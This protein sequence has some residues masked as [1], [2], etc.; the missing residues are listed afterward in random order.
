[1]VGIDSA[2]HTAIN[3]KRNLIRNGDTMYIYIL[4]NTIN[5]K[6]YIG[7]SIKDPRITNGRIHHHFSLRNP[8]CRLIHRAIKKYG[9]DAF[10]IEII[11]YSR[12]SIEALNTIE[13][14]YIVKQNALTPNGYNL[15]TGG[16]NGRPSEETRRKRSK[17]LKGRPKSAEHRSNIA[18]ANRSRKGE[19]HHYYGKSLTKEH[20]L[21][22]SESHKGK[23]ISPEHRAKMRKGWIKR[24]LK[25]HPNQLTLF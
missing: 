16:Q 9:Q 21:K 18:E 23:T 3:G 4:T 10:R 20:R 6:Q 7:Q 14:W 11:H 15:T 5:E 1:M 8:T 12:A 2:Y 25:K 22:M 19:K 17:T 13:Q 24:R